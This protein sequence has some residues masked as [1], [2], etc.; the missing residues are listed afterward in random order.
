MATPEGH[1]LGIGAG[2]VERPPVS[3]QTPGE[4]GSQR[5]WPRI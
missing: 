3:F 5:T 2:L 1:E 4:P